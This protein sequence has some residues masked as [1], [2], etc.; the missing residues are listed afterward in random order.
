MLRHQREVVR[1]IAR[2]MED[3]RA[4]DKVDQGALAVHLGRAS[5]YNRLGYTVQAG[6]EL[7]RAR[8]L[9]PCDS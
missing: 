5:T 3:G 4:L 9:L 8:E 2:I 7:E 1:E 6:R